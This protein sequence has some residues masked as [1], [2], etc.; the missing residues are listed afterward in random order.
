M[1]KVKCRPSY[2]PPHSPGYVF[3]GRGRVECDR[4]NSRRVGVVLVGI[5]PW[6]D[7]TV[8]HQFGVRLSLCRLCHTAHQQK[9]QSPPSDER[10]E[11][12]ETYKK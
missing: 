12:N 4:V 10:S 9:V 5:I 6:V 2:L 8:R 7:Y 3:G 11:T 1:G